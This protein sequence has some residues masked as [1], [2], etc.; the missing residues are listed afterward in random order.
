[1]N[2]TFTGINNLKVLKTKDS[3]N[4]KGLI[5][6]L[7]TDLSDDYRGNDLSLYLK[8]LDRCNKD[9]R[10]YFINRQNPNSIELE[11]I[12]ASP[13]N[14][15]NPAFKLNNMPILFDRDEVLPLFNFMAYLTKN[16]ANSADSKDKAAYIN[17]INKT[18]M[19]EAEKYF[20]V[21]V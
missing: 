3:K 10:N 7:R 5:I 14:F 4:D 12:T 17:M 9:Y 19:Q 8:A 21:E 13:K 6:K 15:F 2:V 18:I 20:N 16:A 1:M 11:C